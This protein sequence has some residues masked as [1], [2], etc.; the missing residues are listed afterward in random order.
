[1][2]GML[3]GKS[4]CER[5]VAESGR[6]RLFGIETTIIV[7]CRFGERARQ[8]FL[9]AVIAVSFCET[10]SARQRQKPIGH[11][12]SGKFRSTKLAA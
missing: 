6:S 11:F 10:V 4:E 9:N 2:F 8:H 1:M 3:F 5:F 7:I 12:R